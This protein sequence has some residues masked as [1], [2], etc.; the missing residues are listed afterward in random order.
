MKMMDVTIDVQLEDVINLVKTN[1]NNLVKL[2][3]DNSN[4]FL[5]VYSNKGGEF[6]REELWILEGYYNTKSKQITLV[7]DSDVIENMAFQLTLLKHL[8][9]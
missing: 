9:E 7:S 5:D 2:K 8:N 4:K 1:F 6:G 3:G